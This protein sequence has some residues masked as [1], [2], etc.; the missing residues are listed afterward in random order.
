LGQRVEDP[1]AVLVGERVPEAVVPS[2][3]DSSDKFALLAAWG[4]TREAEAQ[5]DETEPTDNREVI[6]PPTAMEE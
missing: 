5:H 3:S 2:G 1:V 4:A 6:A